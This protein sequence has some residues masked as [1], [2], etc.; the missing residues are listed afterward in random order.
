MNP[1]AAPTP[2]SRAASRSA[3]SCA[4]ELRP[5][6]TSLANQFQTTAGWPAPIEVRVVDDCSQALTSGSVV[7]SFSGGEDP[8]ALTHVQNGNWTGT[9]VPRNKAAS[10]Q[11]SILS[12][13]T[14]LPISAEPP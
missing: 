8:V 12:S 11:L 5:W 4:T 2:A 10:Q 3:D 9:W 6:I 7:A 13:D 1:P 14:S